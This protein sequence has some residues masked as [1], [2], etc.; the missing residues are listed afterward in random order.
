MS[1]PKKPPEPIQEDFDEFLEWTAEEEE[2]F[3]SILNEKE[4]DDTPKEE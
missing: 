2:A 4:D 1:T 3:L